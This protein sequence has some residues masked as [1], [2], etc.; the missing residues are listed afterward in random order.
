MKI[1]KVLVASIFS[2]IISSNV[3]AATV[4]SATTPL[5]G[6]Y[7]QI[8]IQTCSADNTNV[9]PTGYQSTYTNH[10]IGTIT[11]TADPGS[12]TGTTALQGISGWL[13]TTALKAFPTPVPLF[14]GVTADPTSPTIKLVETPI[15]WGTASI[16]S[17]NG[18]ITS[19]YASV[20]NPV[21]AP[22][23]GYFILTSFTYAVPANNNGNKIGYAYYYIKT[24]KTNWIRFTSYTSNTTATTRAISG[25][26][27]GTGTQVMSITPPLSAVPTNYNFDCIVSGILTQ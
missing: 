22:E 9:L 20:V 10:Q 14:S 18:V 15:E 17:T 11:Y 3:F 19:P 7:S 8:Q 25:T 26:Y 16:Q 21:M 12:Y 5:S 4:K 13:A 1:T 23:V 24:G 27:M 2:Y 6:T